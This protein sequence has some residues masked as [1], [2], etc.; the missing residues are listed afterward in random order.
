MNGGGIRGGKVYPPGTAITRRDVLA[1]LPFDNRVVTIEISGA[2]LKRAIENGLS[3]LPNPAGRFPQVSG[4]TVEAD[5]EPAGRQPRRCRSRSAARR[6][7]RSKTYR[8]ATND[9]LARGGDGYAMFRDAKPL[10][11]A[12]DAP[13]LAN[14]V[15]DYISRLG[16]VRTR[17]GAV[18]RG[19]SWRGEARSWNRYPPPSTG[20]RRMTYRSDGF[21]A[22]GARARGMTGRMIRLTRTAARRRSPCRRSAG[23]RARPAPP[24][25][26]ASSPLAAWRRP[27]RRARSRRRAFRHER[28]DVLLAV[29]RDHEPQPAKLGMTPAD[30]RES[31][32][33]ARTCL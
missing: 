4:L 2:R 18:A 25:R 32:R 28:H 14:E 29:A 11:P 17:P 1:E 27:P 31:R 13:L 21:R 26:S 16:T 15:M 8:V 22:C 33:D 19:A 23:C 12:A 3:Q 10:L 6:S 20:H 7:T 30:L 5:A 24:R 9:F